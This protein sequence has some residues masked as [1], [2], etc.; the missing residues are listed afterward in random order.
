MGNR[1][2]YPLE[3]AYKGFF[4]DG[5]S[6]IISQMELAMSVNRCGE[7]PFQKFL[8]TSVCLY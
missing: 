8:D 2:E 1:S 7:E 3:R 4:L 5:I 6:S